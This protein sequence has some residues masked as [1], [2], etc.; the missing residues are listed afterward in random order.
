MGSRVSEGALDGQTGGRESGEG[1]SPA[2][3]AGAVLHHAE[4]HAGAGGGWRR[5][6]AGSIVV[7]GQSG[8]AVAVGEVDTDFGGFAVF[9][10]IGDGFLGDAVQV[11]GGVPG[12]G[13]E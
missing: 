12:D 13:W 6:K 3:D 4:A 11:D 2:D 7:D 1:E 5:R 9:D 10:G 8:L